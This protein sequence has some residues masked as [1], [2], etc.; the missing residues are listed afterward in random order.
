MRSS[1]RRARCWPYDSA[2]FAL[3]DSGTVNQV[4]MPLAA[5]LLDLVE[6]RAPASR[7]WLRLIGDTDD[8]AVLETA[9]AEASRRVGA[10]A[11]ALDEAE[12]ASLARVGVSWSLGA[13]GV[14]DVVR[15]A[16]LLIAAQRAPAEV[17][18]FIVRRRQS[19]DV[20]Q[21]AAL[22]RALPLLPDAR[23]WV[24]IAIEAPRGD[25]RAV[26]EALACDNPYP[27]AHFHA[28]H[29]DDLVLAVLEADLPLARI[30]GLGP[31]VTERLAAAAARFVATRRAA[32][33]RP[34]PELW[35]LSWSSA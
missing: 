6:R 5:Q 33:R 1:V 18:G 22:M 10:A 30:V 21:R 34:P 12:V 31:R 2:A 35:R 23:Q 15:V 13:W 27:A 14:D 3:L 7:A 8:V 28:L 4:S 9:F 11:L 25:V 32:G 26:L 24:A 29:F 20:R 19:G 16:T 17:E